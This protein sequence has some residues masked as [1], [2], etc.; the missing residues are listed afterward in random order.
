MPGNVDLSLK[1]MPLQRKPFCI[2]PLKNGSLAL[3]GSPS[4][5]RPNVFWLLCKRRFSLRGRVGQNESRCLLSNKK[6]M[7]SFALGKLSGRATTVGGRYV[8][9]VHFDCS[10]TLGRL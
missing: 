6:G 7:D 5:V 1:K 2:R 8:G 3:A 10:S 4:L 9:R